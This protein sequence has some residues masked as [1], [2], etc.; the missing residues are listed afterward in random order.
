MTILTHQPI[1]RGAEDLRV[2]S[3]ITTVLLIMIVVMIIR[4]VFARRRNRLRA[5]SR[6]DIAPGVR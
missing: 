5:R 3:V 2:R 4:D 6:G 1:I